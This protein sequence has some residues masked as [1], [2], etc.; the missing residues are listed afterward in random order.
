MERIGSIGG[1]D[2][3][4]A[5]NGRSL[6]AGNYLE[7]RWVQLLLYDEGMRSPVVS[8]LSSLIAV[9]LLGAL[10]ERAIAEPSVSV[11]NRAVHAGQFGIGLAAGHEWQIDQRDGDQ[12]SVLAHW[13]A[14]SRLSAE[15][16]Y[17]KTEFDGGR[18]NRRIGGALS[19][20]VGNL[21]WL[22]PY[23][24][25]GGG[26]SGSESRHTYAEAGAGVKF[27][28]SDRF[29]LMLDVRSGQQLAATGKGEPNV[30]A[31]AQRP[32]SG[33]QSSTDN[34][35]FDYSRWRLVGMIYF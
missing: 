2:D 6:F 13:R 21:S 1:H 35:S 3:P 7:Y 17:G 14:T 27:P 24:V 22:A 5:I 18:V 34:E 28:L 10:P 33:S 16:E 23:L 19:L 15:F 12:V 20:R 25:V 30:V 31:L 26:V 32:A 9:G 8:I 11:E 4:M 29:V